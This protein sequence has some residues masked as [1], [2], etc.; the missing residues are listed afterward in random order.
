[1]SKSVKLRLLLAVAVLSW[2]SLGIIITQ[3][4]PE[5][6][7][8]QYAFFASL[9]AALIASLTLAAYFFSFRLFASEA[10]RGNMARSLQQGGLWATFF[11]AT[12]I[13]QLS[14]ALSVVTGIIMLVLF[15]LAG[16]VVLT[17]K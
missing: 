1:M 17:R 13:M 9:Y 7:V 3:V 2:A 4:S 10:R 8:S 16:A 15:G 14:R 6:A 11:V 5:A 12:A